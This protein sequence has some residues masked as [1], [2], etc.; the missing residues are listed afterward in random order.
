M[1]GIQTDA[2]P[3]MRFTQQGDPDNAVAAAWPVYWAT[4]AASTAAV[5]VEL[6]PGMRLPRHTD[7]AEEL[8]VI[9]DGEIEAT[10]GE[11]RLRAGAGGLVLI[12]AMAPHG[13]INS[14]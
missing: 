14:G 11:R 13:A 8:L 5:Y 12:P 1:S 7:S 6:E 2:L 4:G 3:L 9:L 10:V